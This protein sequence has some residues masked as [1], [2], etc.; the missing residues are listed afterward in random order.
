MFF[1]AHVPT[2]A[3][4]AE[5]SGALSSPQE[6]KNVLIVAVSN[7]AEINLTEVFIS[8]L[9]YFFFSVTARTE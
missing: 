8:C 7:R 3:V 4:S 9:F 6:L 2:I 1:T 5:L